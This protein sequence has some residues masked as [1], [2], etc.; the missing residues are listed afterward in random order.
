METQQISKKSNEEQLLKG[1]K[2]STWDHKAE[3]GGV[4]GTAQ[5]LGTYHLGLLPCWAFQQKV[6]GALNSEF[7]SVPGRHLY[8]REKQEEEAAFS[9]GCSE[10][11]A[12][13]SLP[14]S[15]PPP[16]PQAE[17][18]QDT[19]SC[20]VCRVCA[21]VCRSRLFPFVLIQP[22]VFQLGL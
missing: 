21:L 3:G 16:G 9:G 8:C 18:V 12:V 13:P 14:T 22:F 19:S 1:M 6:S 10:D 4:M 15:P 17:R 7:R 5:S 11:R 20:C 2:I